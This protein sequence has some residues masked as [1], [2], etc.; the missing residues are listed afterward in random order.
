MHPQDD[1][2]NEN[3]FMNKNK[4]LRTYSN[5][6]IMILA[7]GLQQVVSLLELRQIH[8]MNDLLAILVHQC[9]NIYQES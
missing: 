5:N 8:F 2:V 4:L 3:L 7:M 6:D 1:G 9:G